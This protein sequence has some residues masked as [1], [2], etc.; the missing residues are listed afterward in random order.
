MLRGAVVAVA[1][2][3]AHG[4]VSEGEAAGSRVVCDLNGLDFLG[5]SGLGVLVE[6]EDHARRHGVEFVVAAQTRRVCRV[7]E[8]TGLDRRFS[9]R[10]TL[11]SATAAMTRASEYVGPVA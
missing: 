9:L 1:A 8:L 7:L 4:R 3:V 10:P 6:I 2:E 5:A 11:K